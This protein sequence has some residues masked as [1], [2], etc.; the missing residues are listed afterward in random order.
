MWFHHRNVPSLHFECPTCLFRWQTQGQISDSHPIYFH[1]WTRPILIWKYQIQCTF[2]ASMFM[3][4]IWLELGH[5]NHVVRIQGKYKN[6][7]NNDN[8]YLMRKIHHFR[9][10]SLLFMCMLAL[11]SVLT[12]APLSPLYMAH[13]YWKRRPVTSM[14]HP[15]PT[16]LQDGPQHAA[17]NALSI[18]HRERIVPH[19]CFPAPK[20]QH[21]CSVYDELGPTKQCH[22]QRLITSL[23]EPNGLRSLAQ[24]DKVNDSVERTLVSEFLSTHL[25]L[26]SLFAS[27]CTK[28]GRCLWPLTVWVGLESLIHLE[29]WLCPLIAI[30][31]YGNAVCNRLKSKATNHLIFLLK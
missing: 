24:L 14:S 22:D 9:N 10:R 23:T 11:H 21:V 15:W 8:K 18:W 30:S 17:L 6:I 29:R 13:R 3:F 19:D 20:V 28:D 5:L 1:I 27:V 12:I 2:L 7:D 4:Q 26:V 31:V 16:A 25:V